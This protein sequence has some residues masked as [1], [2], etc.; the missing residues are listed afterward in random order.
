M[1]VYD[2]PYATDI[3]KRPA[4][5]M[6]FSIVTIVIIV[7]NVTNVINETNA[8]SPFLQQQPNSP[9][10]HFFAL[11]FLHKPIILFKFATA[12]E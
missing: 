1:T 2:Y 3:L 8:I 4:L 12:T 6:N 11:K 10:L 7:T 5:M 9:F